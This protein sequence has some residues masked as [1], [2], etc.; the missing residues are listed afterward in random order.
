MDGKG[1]GLVKE[2]GE[3]GE[4]LRFPRVVV[5]EESDEWGSDPLQRRIPQSC[6]PREWITATR[7]NIKSQRDNPHREFARQ[8]DRSDE[9]RYTIS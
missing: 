3:T 7:S 4:V 2:T 9:V 6:H 1:A 8:S 5:V